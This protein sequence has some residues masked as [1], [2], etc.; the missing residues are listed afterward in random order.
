MLCSQIRRINIVKITILH[1]AIYRF[2][3]TPNE[4][5]M[6]FST[7]LEQKLLKF[8][9]KHKRHQIAKTILRKKYK[10]GGIGLLDFKLYYKTIVIKTVLLTHKQTHRTEERAQ[11]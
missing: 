3:A 2:S 9:W 5:S 8:V 1:K 11:K 10:T 6:A 4:L 7:E